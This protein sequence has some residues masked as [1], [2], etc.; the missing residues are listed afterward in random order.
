[1]KF[2]PVIKWS[3]SKRALSEEI[4]QYFP[5]EINTYYEPF[6][7][8]CSMLYQLLNSD[9]KVNKYVCSDVNE[10]LISYFKLVKDNPISIYEEY[11]KR[12][13]NLTSFE[14]IK[15]KQIY[16][17]QVRDSYNKTKNTYDFIF[18]TRTSANG[19]IRYNSK[20]EFNA[21]FHLTRNGINPET[22][23]QIILEWSNKLNE[24]NVEFVCCDYK[25]I[26][27]K[28]N[29]FMYL[30][31]PYADTDSM[32]FGELQLEEFFTYLRE[33]NCNY[34]LSFNG[35]R[36]NEDTTYDIPSDLYTKHIYMKSGNS[37][38]KKLQQ[39]IDKVQE[40]LYI[41]Q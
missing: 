25:N 6:C 35:K 30:D 11:N 14:D 15:D 1:M 31:P 38:F 37:G 23:K 40:S 12:W 27:P 2:Q 3:G 18:L 26:K 39:E 21:P 34:L 32:Y 17:N 10:E 29:D 9:I 33:L 16:Y 19:L 8:S 28:E 4:I 7:G 36:S 22:F 41:K 20:G 5:K 13:L 24:N